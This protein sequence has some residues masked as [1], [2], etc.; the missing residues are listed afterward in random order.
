M[1]KI[2]VSTFLTMDG[3]LQAPGGSDEDRTGGFD[4]G[5]WMFHYGDDVTDK[6]HEDLIATPFDLLVTEFIDGYT[7]VLHTRQKTLIRQKGF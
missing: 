7:L 6:A 3:V 4:W 5:G 2:I 1:R